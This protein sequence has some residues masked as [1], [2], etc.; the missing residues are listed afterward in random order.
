MSDELHTLLGDAEPIDGGAVAV[1]APPPP[2]SP[3][4]IE[5]DRWTRRAGARVA[6]QWREMRSPIPGDDGV[7][8]PPDDDEQAV[9][10]RM[11]DANVAAD[12]IATLLAPDPA[13][14]ERPEDE[15]RARWWKQLIESPESA[16]LRARTIGR[17]EIAEIAAAELAR[18]W[19]EYVV[20]HPEP[21]KQDGE[22]DDG[23]DGDEHESAQDAVDRIR[24]TR[25][26]LQQATDAADMA[27]SVGQGL[28]LGQGG[29]ADAKALARYTRRL[30]QS[31]NLAAVM[32]MAGRFIAKANRLQ[33][34]RTNLPGMETAGIELSGDLARVLPIES[35]LI[36]G[37]VPE[38]E[39]LALLRLAERRSL[40]VKRVARTVQEMGPI[41]VSVDESGSMSGDR[42][43]AAKGLALAMA[44][45]A[46]AQKRPFVLCAWSGTP[47]VRVVT[48][49]QHPE[50]IVAWIED[51]MGGG[52]NL[53]GP[54]MTLT[55]NHWPEYKAGAAADHIIITD[56]EVGVSS[57]L[58]DHYTA[59]AKGAEVR[60][61]GLG[62]GIPR[63][64]TLEEFCDGGV[65]TMPV[66][67]LDNPA[68]DV[69]LS[70]GPTVR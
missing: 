6:E 54:L 26:A 3:T 22:G 17:P 33:R 66:L 47:A 69:V 60:T 11:T 14:A 9:T 15:H 41:V 70:I 48:S 34:Q 12:A 43:A 35:S 25:D 16:G 31:P 32:K 8:S 5:T 13:L 63:A 67:D 49:D 29:A 20:A 39:T 53:T 51:F 56:G 21:E 19:G 40:S 68:V 45:I 4:V 46:R 38:L 57:T 55:M 23:Q 37:A 65:W 64:P 27:E 59:W 42:I 36:A 30:R 24:S 62:I 50:A 1:V 28:G 7:E 44:S 2:P 58:L 61:F 10:E 52:T 18:Q